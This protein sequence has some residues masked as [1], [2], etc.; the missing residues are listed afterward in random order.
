MMK[1]FLNSVRKSLS[2]ASTPQPGTPPDATSIYDLF[3]K[4]NPD[5][6]GK[7]CNDDCESCEVSLPKGFQINEDENL[8][9]HIKGWSTH[10]LV[11]TGKTDWVRD[12]ADEK[13]SVMQAIGKS[14]IKPN[15]GVSPQFV[16]R[17][18]F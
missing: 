2:G 7:D 12:V 9:G 13:G 14:D 1:S 5:V 18:E 16:S 17:L 6:D 10:I 3:P 4:V 11:A 8:Y 15:N